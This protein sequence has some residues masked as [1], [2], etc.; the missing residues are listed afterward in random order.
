MGSRTATG[1]TL[2]LSLGGIDRPPDPS[3]AQSAPEEFSRKPD[4][5]YGLKFGLALTMEDGAAARQGV[6]L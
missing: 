6:A 1:L 4:V 5:I 3:G 2:I